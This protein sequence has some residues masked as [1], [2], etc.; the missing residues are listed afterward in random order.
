LSGDGGGGGGGGLAG[1]GGGGA[2]FTGG[3][4]G[5]GGGSNLVPPGGIVQHGFD[6]S[7]DGNGLVVVSATVGD[8]TCPVAAPSVILAGPRFT[9]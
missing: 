5:G 6:A 7:N 1:G 3:G 4:A 9:G 8:D 2:G